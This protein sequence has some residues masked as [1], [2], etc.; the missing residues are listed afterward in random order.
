[1]ETLEVFLTESYGKSTKSLYKKIVWHPMTNPG[2]NLK[3]NPVK[4]PAGIL[5]EIPE[6]NPGEIPKEIPGGINN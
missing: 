6:R 4:I 3:S 2:S 5:E 1:M